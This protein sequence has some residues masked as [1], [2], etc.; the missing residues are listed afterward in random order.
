MCGEFLLEID[1]KIL[2]AV[3]RYHVNT[4]EQNKF[5]YFQ[6]ALDLWDGIDQLWNWENNFNNFNS[7]FYTINKAC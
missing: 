4:E 7:H 2:V 5:N 6:N 3:D 1:T